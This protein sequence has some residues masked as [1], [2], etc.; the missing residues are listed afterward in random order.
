M[1]Y[2]GDLF[3][4]SYSG[5]GSQVPDPSEPDQRSETWVLWNRQLID[6][7]LYALWGRFRPGV[8]ILLISD[9]CHSGTVSRQV[10][11]LNAAVAT[12]LRNERT[13]ATRGTGAPA[14]DLVD[15]LVRDA[16]REFLPP[17]STARHADFVEQARLLDE[18]LGFQDAAERAG[19]YRTELARSANA[20]APECSVL[21][22]SGCQDNQTSSDGRP[23]PSGHQNGAFT[24]ALRNVWESATDYADLHARI[25]QQM[26]ST[27]SP[28]L[29]WATNRD[30][31]F[32]AQRPFT[33]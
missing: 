7:E 21:L 31:A 19:L 32:E 6:D 1:L 25:L 12:V 33:I 20:P 28:N 23:D 26:P 10:A 14:S 2:P 13:A 24:K 29:F 16:V 15:G 3:L 5:H 30:A 27:Q 17:V 4:I 18:R 11:L 8:R 9:S 22:I